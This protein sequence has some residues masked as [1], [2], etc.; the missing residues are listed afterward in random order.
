MNKSSRR[1]VLK[2]LVKG[3]VL[4]PLG[5]FLPMIARSEDGPKVELD[6]P[7]AVALGYIHESVTEGQT[8]ASCQLY[9]A[10]ETDEWGVCAIFPVKSVAAKG[11]VNPGLKKQLRLVAHL[12][13]SKDHHHILHSYIK[14]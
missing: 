7:Q 10:G 14:S 3:T 8:C 9:T 13:S 11:C 5:S 1:K 6:D 4:V 2:T 12:I